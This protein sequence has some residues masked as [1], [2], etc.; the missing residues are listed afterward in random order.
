MNKLPATTLAVFTVGALAAGAGLSR[1]ELA[2]RLNVDFW[3]LPAYE[4]ELATCQDEEV[5][6]DARCRALVTCM[7]SKEAAVGEL[8][9]GRITLFECAARFRDASAA[10]EDS[11]KYLRKIHPN[12]SA[13]E[14]QCRMVIHWVGS[15][16][17]RDPHAAAVAAR[18]NAELEDHLARHGTVRLPR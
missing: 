2:E 17:Y 13:D 12:L 7:D 4:R 15:L 5:R 1:P 8:R 14:A 9:A 6:L 10:S 11:Q 18:L 16:A 3:N